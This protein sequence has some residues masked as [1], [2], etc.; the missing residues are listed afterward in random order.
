M[1]LSFNAPVSLGLTL[2]GLTVLGVGMVAP[3]LLQNWFTS[4]AQ[5]G[6][7]GPEVVVRCLS[8]VLGHNSWPHFMGN[9]LFILLAGPAVEE[10]YGSW[11][12][13]LF[14]LATA[15][16]T[17]LISAL[18]FHTSIMGASGLAFMFIVLNSITNVRQGELPLTFVLVAGI[19]LGREG[20][21]VFADDNVSQL[22]HILGG[23]L[24][25]AFGL[26]KG[27]KKPQQD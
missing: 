11:T 1:R 19:F 13:L 18:V 24:G 3:D 4:P 8:Y 22:A 27:R 16:I 20:F 23:A 25:G 21:A 14:C 2:G 10:K 5:L 6:S 17:A 12:T 26:M 15:A 9:A 7:F